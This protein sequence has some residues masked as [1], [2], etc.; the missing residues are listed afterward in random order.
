[1][2]WTAGVNNILLGH[3]C[4]TFLHDSP[5]NLS[6][7]DQPNVPIAFIKW[8]QPTSQYKFPAKHLHNS[9][10]QKIT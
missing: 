9:K 10:F 4:Y 8:N 5:D 1:M 7:T 3:L 6:Y 2:Q